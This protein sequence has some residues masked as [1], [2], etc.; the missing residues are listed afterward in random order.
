MARD[1]LGHVVLE[2]VLGKAHGTLRKMPPGT[3]LPQPL[4][5]LHPFL[6]TQPGLA[7]VAETGTST[8]TA[9]KLVTSG[10][11]EAPPNSLAPGQCSI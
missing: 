11:G 1:L 6:D 7:Q 5:A 3:Q 9:H 8:A 10:T 2:P 4:S